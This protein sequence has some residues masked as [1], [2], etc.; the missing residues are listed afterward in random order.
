MIEPLISIIVPVYN[1]EKTIRY[2]L[3][4]IR[5]QSFKNIEVLV[6]DDGSI[7]SS[8]KIINEFCQKDNR[9][10]CYYCENSGPSHAR[11][12]GLDNCK[13][14][15]IGF[16]DSDDYISTDMYEF[17]LRNII[18]NNADLSI[19]GYSFLD[20]NKQFIRNNDDE[21]GFS[22]LY[23]NDE[24][25]KYLFENKRINGSLVNKLFKKS[26]IGSLRFNESISRCE[27]FLFLYDVYKNT[28]RVIYINEI[29]YYVIESK[30]SL[31]RST[32][33]RKDVEQI[34]VFK[35]VFDLYEK[36]HSVYLIDAACG[37]LD[38]ILSG[39]KY[40]LI[41]NI[42]SK[43]EISMWNNEIDK[44]LRICHHSKKLSQF[45]KLKILL[46]KIN[47]KLLYYFYNFAPLKKYKILIKKLINR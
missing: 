4:S 32:P 35:R 20:E 25:L 29:K 16:V 45:T 30:N 46:Y 19:C 22:H 2:C 27:D 3:E 7:D 14:N 11:N 24:C 42:L 12:I 47:P 18:E 21:E 40:F 26:S 34:E 37:Y 10:S 41:P 39:Y 36:E 38:A 9:F 17:L 13:G 31:M 6:I 23:L 8:S 44:C 1:R 5:N 33:S 15:Y 43:K 28:R